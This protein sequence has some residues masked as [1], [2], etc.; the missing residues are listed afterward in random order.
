M[1]LI[2]LPC[3]VL[4]LILSIDDVLQ[5][6]DILNL[7]LTCKDLE[8]VILPSLYRSLDFDLK[9]LSGTKAM[10]SL[11]SSLSAYP[12]R[13]GWV[14][15]A[16]LKC[17]AI[18]SSYATEEQ[19]ALLRLLGLIS[20]ISSLDIKFFDTRSDRLQLLMGYT[21]VHRTHGAAFR[22]HITYPRVPTPEEHPTKSS[23]KIRHAYGHNPTPPPQKQYLSFVEIE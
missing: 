1:S 13:C 10:L 21:H 3:E 19:L 8:T 16:A 23:L 15:K 5:P 7:V 4:D 6:Q 17:D 2:V 22:P 11:L 14:Q 9:Q 18:P 20:S 12:E